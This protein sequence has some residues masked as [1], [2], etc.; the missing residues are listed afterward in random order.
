VVGPSG[1][2]KSFA[3]PYDFVNLLS[4]FVTTC[5]KSRVRV[6][7]WGFSFKVEICGVLPRKCVDLRLAGTTFSSRDVVWNR[8]TN[9]CSRQAGSTLWNR[10][11][12]LVAVLTRRS[13][14]K[15]FSS[16][17]GIYYTKTKEVVQVH[18]VTSCNSHKFHD[19]IRTNNCPTF[20]CCLG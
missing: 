17:D 9:Y 10:I 6:S 12:N 3:L 4:S 11:T 1:P 16:K 5:E 20:T 14:K 2:F 7:P 8:I 15:V 18:P 13:K 19:I